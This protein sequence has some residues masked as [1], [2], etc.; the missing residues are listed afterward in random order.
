MFDKKQTNSVDWTAQ[1]TRRATVSPSYLDFPSKYSQN[2]EPTLAYGLKLICK[3][4][5][6][7]NSIAWESFKQ[8]IQLRAF[9]KLLSKIIRQQVTPLSLE[10]TCDDDKFQWVPKNLFIG[11]MTVFINCHRCGNCYESVPIKSIKQMGDFILNVRD[12]DCNRILVEKLKT[13]F[14]YTADSRISGHMAQDCVIPSVTY[15]KNRFTR[16]PEMIDRF[17][18]KHFHV[19][20]TGAVQKSTHTTHS[21]DVIVQDVPPAET[22]RNRVQKEID[23]LNREYSRLS[24]YTGRK[25]EIVWKNGEV[26]ERVTDLLITNSV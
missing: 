1:C 25:K 18:G 26:T 6:L 9:G 10:Y 4:L 20:F 14:T 17:L 23:A 13:I 24:E 16:T 15:R 3:I 12:Y 19:D 11:S 22:H 21:P 5:F 7:R 2:Y 8:Y